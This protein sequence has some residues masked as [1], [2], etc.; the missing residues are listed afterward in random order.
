MPIEINAHNGQQTFSFS[1]TRLAADPATAP[2]TTPVDDRRRELSF[3]SEFPAPRTALVNGQ[4]AQI[5]EILS[6]AL[7]AADL[8]RLNDG[9][10]LL[11]NH[12][13]D[14]YI[15]VIERAEIGPDRKG[16]AVVRFG[17]SPEADRALQ[18]VDGGILSKISVGYDIQGA[19]FDEKNAILN[20]SRWLPTEISLTTK[21]VDATVGMGRSATGNN[22]LTI[23]TTQT[24]G[25]AMPNGT[26]TQPTGTNGATTVTPSTDDILKQERARVT[27]IESMCAAH[28]FPSDK[29]AEMIR[30]NTSIDQA[31][32]LVLDWLLTTGNR[33]QANM[34]A[35][36]QPDLSETERNSYSLIR[37]INAAITGNWKKAGLELEASNAISKSLGR[38]AAVDQNTG[39][40]GFFMPT[41]VPFYSP[42]QAQRSAYAVGGTALSGTTG[43]TLV[44]Q[45]LLPGEF[46]ELLRNKARVI[47]AG[48]R[49]LSGLVGNVTIPRQTGASTAYWAA[50]GQAV[51]ESEGSFDSTTLSL[52]TLGTRSL[53]TRNMLM[54]STPAIEA[55]VRAD[56]I[57]VLA[58]GIDLAALS[59]TGTNNQP[60]GVALQVTNNA[61]GN[62]VVGGTNGAA[63]TIQHLIQ[64]E[65][66][67]MDANAEFESLAYICNAKTVGALKSLVSTTGQFLW[68]DSS[69]GGRSGTP[70]NINGYPVLR[71][72][73]ASKR[74]TK[75]TQDGSTT[76]KW[77]SELFYGAWEEVL[78]GEWGV[79]EILPNPYDPIAYA[80]GGILL[81]ALQSVD[82]TVRHPQSFSYMNDAIVLPG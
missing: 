25:T 32:G 43:G 22:P 79:L 81:R 30:G 17:N 72:N 56:L 71:S 35:A 15:G 6:H 16:R 33:T 70:G 75:G 46:I 38:G 54:Q 21:P 19:D 4:P 67:V 42:G 41:N 53:I 13:P 64:M 5:R 45:T 60:T 66:A 49:L 82:I 20:V 62:L 77:V 50:E 31:R 27:E 74:L 39:V 73:Q 3:S 57:K 9:A 7:G 48:A 59:G 51:T 47:Q 58:L 37:A 23:Q 44:A 65:A 12:D 63:L 14:N 8:S 36:F 28:H 26:E 2:A 34:G 10:N 52:K 55:I 40:G 11:F 61:S 76:A 69:T 78:I 29:R 80:Q 68:T 24:R 1:A 18:D